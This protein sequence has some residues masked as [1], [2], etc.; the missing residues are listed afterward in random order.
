MGKSGI[1]IGS[2]DGDNVLDIRTNN[3]RLF[4]GRAEDN[5]LD[6]IARNAILD[7]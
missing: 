4:L 3:K 6:L 5:T 7:L 2:V 1:R